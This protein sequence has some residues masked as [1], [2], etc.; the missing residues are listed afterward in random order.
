MSDPGPDLDIDPEPRALQYRLVDAGDEWW[1]I[2]E[3]PAVPRSPD[4][5]VA[6][7]H[8]REILPSD[9]RGH[10][11]RFALPDAAYAELD[12]EPGD[13]VSLPE[14]DGAQAQVMI[15]GLAAAFKPTME[16]MAELAEAVVEGFS[17]AFADAVTV[18]GDDEEDG[19]SAAA[20]R[21]PEPV[22][23]AR[24]RREAQRERERDAAGA[25]Y[26]DD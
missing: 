9:D 1:L 26:P 16:A 6:V 10:V 12:A 8:A 14:A 25:W 17:A 21:L 3:Y 13:V 22:Q 20:G 23:E 24:E 18:D 2:R 5:S 19:E 7:A 15:D 4:E 11:D